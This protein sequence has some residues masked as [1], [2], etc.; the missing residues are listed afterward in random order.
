M[1]IHLRLWCSWKIVGS[2]QIEAY[3]KEIRLRCLKG[4]CDHVIFAVHHRSRQLQPHKISHRAYTS[5]HE[6]HPEALAAA[7]D[8]L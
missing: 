7:V 4:R 5:H 2:K 1:A 6:A 8:H 3:I